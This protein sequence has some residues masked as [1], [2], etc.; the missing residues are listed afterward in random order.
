M[1][2]QKIADMDYEKIIIHPMWY[3]SKARKRL[4]RSLRAIGINFEYEQY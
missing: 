3:D 4:S 1:K 2:A